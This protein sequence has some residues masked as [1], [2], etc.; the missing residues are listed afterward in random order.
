MKPKS[1]APGYLVLLLTGALAALGAKGCAAP[2]PV[3]PE[4]VP[5]NPAPVAI[6]LKGTFFLAVTDNSTPSQDQEIYKGDE[7]LLSML[8]ASGINWY[9]M[10]KDSAEFQTS[11]YKSVLADDH[12]TPPAVV[13]VNQDRTK[14]WSTAA[15]KDVEGVRAWLSGLKG[16]RPPPPEY[17][18]EL[19][20][21][22][23]GGEK[24]YLA[25]LPP[26]KAKLAKPKGGK[27]KDSG[28]PTIPR[29]QWREISRRNLFPA[30]QWIYDQDGIGS[31]VGNGSTGALR[32]VRYL[33]G[34]SDVRLAP[35]CTYAQIN[36][37]RDQG[38]VISDSL[39]AL[40]KT[41][42]I[43]SKTLGGDEKP[44]YL[45]QLPAGWQQ[46]AARFK[47]EEAFH[48]E[49]FDE[50]GSALQCGFI[51]V[52]GI[53]VGNNFNSFTGEGVAGV[54]SGPGNH[55]MM[56]DGM[57]KLSNGQWALD[58]VNSWGTTW[59]PW[60]NGRC[61]LVE[62]H[63]QHGDQPDAY[64]VKTATV[65]P[66]D[67]HKPPVPKQ[68]SK[69]GC[70]GTTDCAC[71]PG[72][73]ACAAC[74]KTK[75]DCA[76]PNDCDCKPGACECKNCTLERTAPT[77]PPPGVRPKKTPRPDGLGYC[78]DQCACGC[79]QGQPCRCG[80]VRPATAPPYQPFSQSF[81]PARGG[82]GGC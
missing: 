81:G 61:Y 56:A 44:F 18:P 5:P 36:G 45:K 50:I 22:V 3:P 57:H 47:I 82:R 52:Y 63:F 80:S 67:P 39:T 68:V 34:M 6:D 28:N 49:T 31:C 79:N 73:C 13:L 14:H 32:R 42:T 17:T 62:G 41:G 35:G 33:S 66:L 38:A 4:P 65:D 75:C 43:T 1:A 78:S 2:G 60:K 10:D 24:R 55:C 48:C 29:A 21:V 54:S 59:G 70:G 27:W 51:V 30:D 71:T 7:A 77:A 23:V 76:S 11:S 25:A 8:R 74:V 26:S 19:P 40:Q 69:C 46:E 53:Q 9:C 58:N 64:A 12:V 20:F 16:A 15:P 37:G 72:D